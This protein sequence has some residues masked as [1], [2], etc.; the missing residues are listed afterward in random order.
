[1]AIIRQKFVS[2]IARLNLSGIILVLQLGAHLKEQNSD[3]TMIMLSVFLC[4]A[5]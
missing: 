5:E 2:A 3:E 1:M 4:R